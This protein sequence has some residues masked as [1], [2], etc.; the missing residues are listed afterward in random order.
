MSQPS[1]IKKPHQNLTPAELI[2]L[3]DLSTDKEIIIHPADKGGAVV[4]QDRTQYT[5]EAYRQLDN[6]KHYTR[7]F[8]DTTTARKD[9]IIRELKTL[10]EENQLPRNA[11]QTLMPKTVRTSPFYLLPKIQKPNNP[12]RPIVSGIDS[13]TDVISG[14]LDRILKPLLKHIPSYIRDT[15]H[16]LNIV[17]EI[18][19]L[20]EDEILVSIDVSALYTSIPHREGIE[21]VRSALTAN[22]NPHLDTETILHLLEI[23]LHNNTF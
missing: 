10:K 3:A 4:I 13:P 1:R 15:K 20:D 21:A 19:A 6:K 5:Q 11:H 9:H 18:H 7:T 8:H 22:P 12:G 2:A 23:V 17:H 14:T 16:F